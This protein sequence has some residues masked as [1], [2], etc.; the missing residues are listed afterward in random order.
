MTPTPPEATTRRWKR[1]LGRF[2]DS[3]G[4]TVDEWQ[5][6]QIGAHHTQLVSAVQHVL[7]KLRLQDTQTALLR[8]DTL[9]EDWN[10]WFNEQFG[11]DS[12]ILLEADPVAIAY[13]LRWY[14]ILLDRQLEVTALL[15]RPPEALIQWTRDVD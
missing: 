7:E 6:A 10:P 1:A 13:G 14:E 3:R 8:R 2:L 11:A 9:M 5:Q 12:K 15:D 4:F